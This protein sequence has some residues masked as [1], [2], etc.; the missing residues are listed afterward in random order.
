MQILGHDIIREILFRSQFF[1]SKSDPE[2]HLQK[3]SLSS[4]F[5][6]IHI[7]SHVKYPC[8]AWMWFFSKFAISYSKPYVIFCLLFSLVFCSLSFDSLSVFLTR[9]TW[10]SS[11]QIEIVLEN[12]RQKARRRRESRLV[13]TKSTQS[14]FEIDV[15]CFLKVILV[16]IWAYRKCLYLYK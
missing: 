12:E 4:Y 3:S 5:T 1:L 15:K 9:A 14:Y 7:N 10:E 13:K 8:N 6:F 2:G 16:I 11:I